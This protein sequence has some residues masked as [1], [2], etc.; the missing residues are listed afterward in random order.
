MPDRL[1]LFLVEDDPDFVLLI[2]RSLERANHEVV[3]CGTAADALIV[4]G[5][6]QFNL[7]ILDWQLPDMDGLELIQRLHRDNLNPLEEAAAYQQLIEDF[8]LTHDAV[9]AQVGRHPNASS[10]ATVSGSFSSLT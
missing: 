10:S 8:G 6:T 2:R 7:V 1:R 4:L 3:T 5:Q 9:A